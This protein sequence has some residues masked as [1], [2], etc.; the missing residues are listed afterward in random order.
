MALNVGY[1]A[2]E[3]TQ[4]LGRNPTLTL[5]TIITVAVSLTF[6]GVGLLLRQGVDDLTVR[7][8]GDVELIVFL[9]TEITEEQRAA[10]ESSLEENPEVRDF[11][12]FDSKES[13]AEAQELFADQPTMLRLLREGDVP[14]S[15]RVEPTN[16]DVQAVIALRSTYE[17]QPG[18]KGVESATE[19]IRAIQELSQKLNRGVLWASLISAGVAVLLIYNTIRTAMFARRRE[20]E[21]MKLVGATN[22]FIRIPFIVEGMVQALLGGLV[23]VLMLLGVNAGL[24]RSLADTEYFELF[25][26]FEF[27]TGTVISAA[28]LPM[29][30]GLFIGIVGSGFAVGRF[31]D[32]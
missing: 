8:K 11:T 2:R 13:Y 9:D 19:V 32:V 12:Y 10:I 27:T 22:W 1:V 15:F 24:F 17:S 21:V 6:A 25:E 29:I 31:L 5:A 20:I 14:T 7:F 30:F 18:V 16:P 28:I 4:N 26:A 3:T 23:S